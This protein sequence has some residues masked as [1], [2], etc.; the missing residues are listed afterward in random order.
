MEKLSNRRKMLGYLMIAI[1]F[2]IILFWFSIIWSLTIIENPTLFEA[3][4]M[5]CKFFVPLGLFGVT[6]NIAGFLLDNTKK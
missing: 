1:S 5:L 6:C 3:F 2:F 4:W